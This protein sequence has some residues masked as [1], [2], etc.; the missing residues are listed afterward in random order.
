M[1]AAIL[2]LASASFA[3]GVLVRDYVAAEMFL[4]SVGLA[5][6]AI[7]EGLPATMTITLAIGVQCMAGRNAIIRR[8][9]AVKTVATVGVICSDQG[10]APSPATAMTVATIYSGERLLTVAGASAC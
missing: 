4:A 10:P 1:T 7:P 9:P 5:V 2:V 6:A 3:F 8:L